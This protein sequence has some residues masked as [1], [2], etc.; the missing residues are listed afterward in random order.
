MLWRNEQVLSCPVSR[1]QWLNIDQVVILC[2]IV[3]GNGQLSEVKTI[4]QDKKGKCSKAVK[5]MTL[6]IFSE[7]FMSIKINI[8]QAIF[9]RITKNHKKLTLQMK[10]Y[11]LS[12][13][14]ALSWTLNK[15]P[16]SSKVMNILQTARE[17][18]LL[19]D[20]DDIENLGE[21]KSHHFSFVCK[22]VCSRN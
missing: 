10:F 19:F 13:W 11:K 12:H 5:H 20:A 7:K 17:R 21:R 16:P 8:F 9:G 15:V 3:K 1:I 4:H 22:F 6:N 2:N 14:P 18:G